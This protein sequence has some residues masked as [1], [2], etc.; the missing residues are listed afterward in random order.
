MGF[1][2]SF[3]HMTHSFTRDAKILDHKVEHGV[4]AIHNDVKEVAHFV[5]KEENKIVDATTG[6]VHGISNAL[7]E[8]MIGV[9]VVGGIFLMSK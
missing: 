1:T 9:A 4:Q 6:L 2:K 8:I 5:A 3:K 7:P